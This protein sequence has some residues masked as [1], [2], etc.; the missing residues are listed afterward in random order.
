MDRLYKLRDLVTRPQ[1]ASTEMLIEA[2]EVSLAT[3]KRDIVFARDQM[4][5]PIVFDRHRAV[6]RTEQSMLSEAVRSEVPGLWFSASEIHALL[7]MQQLLANLDNGGLLSSHIQ[8]LTRRLEQMLAKGSLGSPELS[9]RIRILAMAARHFSLPHFRA[10]GTAV[11]Q[12]RRLVICYQSRG[13][14]ETSEREVSPQRLVHYRDNWYLDAW[15]HLRKDLRSFSVDAMTSVRILDKPA[16]D[17]PEAELTAIVA[18]GYGIF[19]GKQVKWARLRF[20]APTAHWIS[21]EVWHPQQRGKWDQQKRWC[22]EIP[23]SDPRE[24]AMDIMRHVPHVQV[25]APKAL[26]ELVLGRLRDGIEK[27]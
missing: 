5:I 1:G 6:Y 21:A 11:L 24:L 23:F 20:S 27:I 26:R 12:R 18:S 19:S 8:P 4:G 15:C 16:I 10:V 7:A 2:L 14:G 3:F 25:L 13:K 17:I 9:S 22:L